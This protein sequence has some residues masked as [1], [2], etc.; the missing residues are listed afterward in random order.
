M[1]I[2]AGEILFVDTNVLLVATDESRPHHREAK[3]LFASVGAS[4][5][6]LALSGQILREYL[7]VATRAVQDNGL[8]LSVDQAL[9]NLAAFA[10]RAVFY[11]ENEAVS[12]RLRALCAGGRLKG[13]RLHDASVAAT[14]L[15]HGL[16]TLI[17]E[18]PRDFQEFAEVKTVGLQALRP[19]TGG[20][21]PARE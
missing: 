12:L 7:V 1:E 4:G 21:A 20:A 19:V 15:A 8:G 17:T 11:D 6:H 14:L 3:A 9:G 5:Y 10:R 16:S 13:K 2:K 18:N